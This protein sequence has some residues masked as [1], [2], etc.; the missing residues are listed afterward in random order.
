M[1][2]FATA[3]LLAAL[4]L[5][6]TAL[7]LRRTPA[8]AR[9]KRE[10]ALALHR[11]QLRELD[12]DAALGLVGEGEHGG[13]RLE[14]ERRLLAAAGD[15]DA[16]TTTDTGRTPLVATL[17]AIPVLAAALYAIGGHPRFGADPLGPR[18]AAEARANARADAMIAQ[19]RAGIAGLD[20]RSDEAHGGNVLLGT[21]EAR[22]GRW[23]EA[24]RAWRAALASGFDPAL[25]DE[26]AEAGIL[27]AGGRVGDDDAALLRQALAQA[28]A[29]AA[30][31]LSAEARL[32]QREHQSLPP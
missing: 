5:L 15:T 29:D 18:L 3:F 9:G 6:P 26:A 32:A 12:R 19:L 20:P 17:V 11:A 2:L 23:P 10:A 31:R 16:T 24:A 8:P 14:I 7:L 27:A 13:A 30:W 25:A 1:T 4:A 28:P 21:I 22:L